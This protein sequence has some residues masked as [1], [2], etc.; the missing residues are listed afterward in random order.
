MVRAAQ[1]CSESLLPVCA[2]TGGCEYHVENYSFPF[3]RRYSVPGRHDG[4]TATAEI[5]NQGVCFVVSRIGPEGSEVRDRAD[6]VL[7]Y[8]IAPA[9]RAC[10]YEARRADHILQPGII[11]QQIIADLINAPMV[12]ADLSGHNPNVFYELAIRQVFRKPLV[13]I[14]NEEE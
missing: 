3:K 12:V 9:A 2:G 11:T 1:R 10:G 13:Q 8:I 7:E 4:S 6:Q 14:I 5:A